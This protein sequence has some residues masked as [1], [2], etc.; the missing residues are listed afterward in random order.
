MQKRKTILLLLAVDC[1]DC[2]QAI[3]VS[4]AGGKSRLDQRVLP[5]SGTNQKLSGCTSCNG[6]NSF[7]ACARVV[8]CM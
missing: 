7:Y 1:D 4:H 6:N 2:L 8:V 3:A 5:P